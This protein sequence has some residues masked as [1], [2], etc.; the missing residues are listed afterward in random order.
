MCALDTV[1]RKLSTGQR[2]ALRLR[3]RQVMAHLELRRTCF[4]LEDERQKRDGVLRMANN[5]GEALYPDSRN[6]V[7][8]KQDQRLVRVP[9]A[10]RQH[11][12]ALGDYVSLHTTRE[13]LTVCGTTKDL[14][15]KPPVRDFARVHRKY[16]YIV[17][18]DR[19]LAIEADVALPGG[20][21]VWLRPSRPSAF[22]PAVCTKPA[23]WDG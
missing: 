20:V 13:Q 12:E 19:I 1:P 22:P 9:T 2:E 16:K 15:T 3:A 23:C 17:C 7:F 14:E 8:I 10:G 4:Q 18:L 5:A 11:V 21:I 6:D